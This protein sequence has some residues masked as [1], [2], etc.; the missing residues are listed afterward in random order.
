MVFGLCLKCV[1]SFS[2]NYSK[3]IKEFKMN[4]RKKPIYL[5]ASSSWF[6]LNQKSL[7][8]SHSFSFHIVLSILLWSLKSFISLCPASFQSFTEKVT[9]CNYWN[10]TSNAKKKE[11]TKKKNFDQFVGVTTA[12]YQNNVQKR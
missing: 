8:L 1:F 11:K 5:I 10:T 9:Q 7:K 3:R 6:T 2:N 4:K 12:K